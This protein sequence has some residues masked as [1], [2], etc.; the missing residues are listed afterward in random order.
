MNVAS[1]SLL[2]A[3]LKIGSD[4]RLSGVATQFIPTGCNKHSVVAL[5]LHEPSKSELVERTTPRQMFAMFGC[6]ACYA[7]IFSTVVFGHKC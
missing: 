2:S 3:A 5:V 7:N 6:V 1:C 4:V